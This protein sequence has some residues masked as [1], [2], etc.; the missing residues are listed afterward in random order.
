MKFFVIED[1]EAEDRLAHLFNCYIS[2][3]RLL[4]AIAL[5]RETMRELRGLKDLIRTENGL[6]TEEV[7]QYFKREA[8]F[9]SLTVLGNSLHNFHWAVTSV[10]K[11]LETFFTEFEGDLHA[12]AVAQR[13]RFYQQHGSEDA[14]DY[15][16][17]GRVLR[18]EDEASLKK[19][20]LWD[21]L[22]KF[23]HEAG[24][25]GR[26]QEQI[27]SSSAENFAEFT[28]LVE[29]ANDFSVAKIFQKMGHAIPV[30]HRG[31]D[32]E[33][34]VLDFP[35]QVEADLNQ[36]IDNQRLGQAFGV[37]WDRGQHLAAFFRTFDRHDVDNYALLLSSARQLLSCAHCV[38]PA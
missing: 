21:E 22:A 11:T 19:W 20:G 3:L 28:S 32:G 8:S 17:A 12:Y 31:S 38:T 18:K 33:L 35:S 29:R 26:R 36:R 5:P 23:F 2:K 25:A 30:A 15:D 16:G 34:K 27:G 10:I 1:I 13:Y 24:E 6:E 37:V 9:Y 7:A 4:D 14:A